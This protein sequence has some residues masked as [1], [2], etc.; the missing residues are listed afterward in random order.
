MTP[1]SFE[2]GVVIDQNGTARYGGVP[3]GQYHSVV[4]VQ[5]VGDTVNSNYPPSIVTCAGR[6]LGCNNDGDAAEALLAAWKM[7]QLGIDI[8]GNL[9]PDGIWILRIHSLAFSSSADPNDNP[10]IV[11]KVHFNHHNS[12]G[13]SSASKPTGN[14]VMSIDLEAGTF[15]HKNKEF[16]FDNQAEMIKKLK[17]HIFANTTVNSGK[18]G[19]NK[20]KKGS[21]G[22]S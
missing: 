6:N 13:S 8:D 19:S 15:H 21:G 2:N 4:Y 12:H 10:K 17:D 14:K 11:A 22:Q 20:K 1:K 5:L 7:Q 3:I 18:S 16:T 9:H